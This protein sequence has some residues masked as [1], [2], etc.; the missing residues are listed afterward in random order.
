MIREYY[1]TLGENEK[2]VAEFKS[3]F[4]G[5]ET[6][7]EKKIIVAEKVIPQ[8]KEMGFTLSLEDFFPS[9]N[10]IED[11]ELSN[12]SGGGEVREHDY[13]RLCNTG[14]H[15]KFTVL[16]FEKFFSKMQ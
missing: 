14:E 3:F 8:A 4:K 10:E 7:E 6:Y 16:D 9:R 11:A 1:E 12:V 13:N 15:G 2:R 5:G